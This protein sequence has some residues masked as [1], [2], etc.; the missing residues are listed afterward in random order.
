MVPGYP[1]APAHQPGHPFGSPLPL[2][3][4]LASSRRAAATAPPVQPAGHPMPTNRHGVGPPH[5]PGNARPN[6]PPWAQAAP[7]TAHGQAAQQARNYA[8]GRGY[9]DPHYQ[10]LALSPHGY[11]IPPGQPNASAPQDRARDNVVDGIEFAAERG[12]R[13]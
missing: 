11:P 2:D 6:Y 5:L 8:G 10:H 9:P 3:M 12:R 13:R 7:G 4:P 1:P